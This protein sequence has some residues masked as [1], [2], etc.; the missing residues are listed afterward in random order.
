MSQRSQ[1]T[2]PT[3]EQILADMEAEIAAAIDRA[4]TRL[5]QLAE[6]SSSPSRDGQ[7]RQPLD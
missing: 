1:P 7:S 6:L 3:E 2:A 5:D 4:F